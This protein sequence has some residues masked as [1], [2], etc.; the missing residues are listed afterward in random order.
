MEEAMQG[1]A[2]FAGGCFWCT[3]AVLQE[4]AGVHSVVSGYTGGHTQNPTYEQ[5]GSGKTGHAE[6]VEV[7]Y[8]P[9]KVSYQ[10]LLDVYWESIDPTDRNGQF[11]DRGSQYRTAIFYLNDEQ[12]RLAESSKVANEKM[13]GQSITTAIEPAQIFYPAEEYHQ[14]YYRTNPLHYNAYKKGSGREPKLRQI[15]GKNKD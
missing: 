12:K 15:W 1:Q 7:R 14:D 6:A 3:E 13:I 5:I 10:T 4:V 8:N 2:I 11:F 9:A